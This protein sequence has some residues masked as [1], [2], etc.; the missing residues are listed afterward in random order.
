MRVDD[1][2][3]NASQLADDVGNAPGGPAGLTH[4]A[5][6]RAG[7]M[8]YAC[9]RTSGEAVLTALWIIL[10]LRTASTGT[11]SDAPEEAPGQVAT[12]GCFR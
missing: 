9:L 2:F 4:A 8:W 11:V 12:L 7:G 1:A 5:V 3:Q 10:Q 6:A